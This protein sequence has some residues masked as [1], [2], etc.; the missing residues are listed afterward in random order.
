MLSSTEPVCAC[1]CA[2]A[3]ACSSR[4]SD[5]SC[6][7]VVCSV[8]QREV[9]AGD[10]FSLGPRATALHQ[11]LHWERTATGMPEFHTHDC[12]HSREEANKPMYT[13]TEEYGGVFRMFS[14]TL[15]IH[16]VLYF[17]T[18]TQ[19]DF[20]H[21]EQHLSR[22]YF[23]SIYRCNLISYPA[24]LL[25]CK[26]FIY[27]HFRFLWFYFFIIMFFLFIWKTGINYSTNKFTLSRFAVKMQF[28]TK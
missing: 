8:G 4:L 24:N 3:C 17:L 13:E 11:S 10:Y 28:L 12:D 23:A 2:C 19:V 7:A 27:Y 25:I 5:V 26:L 15:R 16:L 21:S 18:L 1:A 22:R 20:C 6:V 14:Q 9:P